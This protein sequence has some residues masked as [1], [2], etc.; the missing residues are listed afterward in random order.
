MTMLV[1]NNFQSKL[2]LAC[3]LVLLETSQPDPWCF[4]KQTEIKRLF[5]L[6]QASNSIT[7]LYLE[8]EV[9]GPPETFLTYYVV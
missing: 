2:T 4:L 8:A 9:L 3:D 1:C 5:T 7:F 6:V